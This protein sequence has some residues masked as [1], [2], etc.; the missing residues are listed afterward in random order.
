MRR[1]ITWL[2]VLALL[3][4]GWWYAA[5]WGVARGADL[6]MQELRAQGWQ[7]EIGDHRQGGYPLT[8][9]SQVS[10]LRISEPLVPV[11]YAVP[12]LTLSA[13]AYWPGYLTLH[14]PD[15]AVEVTTPHGPVRGLFSQGEAR[16]NLRP[17]PALQ[18]A[19]V[20][21]SSGAWTIRATEET[22]VGASDLRALVVQGTKDR[23]TYNAGFSATGFTPGDS[24]RAGLALA[25]DWP[26]AF[27]ELNADLSVRFDRPFDRHAATGQPPQP[28]AIKLRQAALEW[29]DIRFTAHADLTLD[30]QGIPT[31]E[32]TLRVTKWEQLLSLFRRA[33]PDL[34]LEQAEVMLRAMANMDNDPGTLDLR[35]SFRE[36]QMFMGPIAL[37]P[38]P[39]LVL[40]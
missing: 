10:G 40:K 6:L 1:L 14:L 28:R 9:R 21:F 25:D 23:R 26:L 13:A 22:I 19:R 30:A 20:G 32:A 18:L 7:I 24:L 8:L 15:D 39:R 38:A 34:P 29:G 4:S 16:L 27:E 31:G 5:T 33:A 35:F 17:G 3:W 2:C 11:Q 36:G 12:A 37:G